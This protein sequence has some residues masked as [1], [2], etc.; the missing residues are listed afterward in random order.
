VAET[1]AVEAKYTIKSDVIAGVTGGY[2]KFL[3][4]NG[5]KKWEFTVGY[6]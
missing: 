2:L 6:T 4:S 3:I 5:D 1:K